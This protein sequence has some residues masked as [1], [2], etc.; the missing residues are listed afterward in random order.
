M[1]AQSNN[2][3]DETV[4]NAAG[5]YDAKGSLRD[6]NGS[7]Y[8]TEKSAAEYE[9]LIA[10][11]YKYL[12]NRR[13]RMDNLYWVVDETGKECI[14]KMRLAQKL[15]YLGLWHCSLVLK[16]RQHGI[17]TLICLMDF[18]TCF[19]NSN[20]AAV[21]VAHNKEDAEG[22]F[23]SKI[24][25]AYN[26]LP[27]F[28]KDANPASQS[29]ARKLTFRNG[30][31]IRVTTSGRSGT[32]QLAHISE[33]GKI[34]AKY[35]EKARE[36]VT[37]TLNTVHPG[38]L[39]TIESTAEGREGKFYDM[40]EVAQQFELAGTPLTQLDYK[41]F[42]FGWQDNPLNVLSLEDTASTV[43]LDYQ[44]E[45]FDEIENELRINLPANK[46][47][48]YV[49]KWNVQ[50]DD[51]KREHP[52]TAAEAFET[53]I[54]GSFYRVQFLKI[55]AEGRICTVPFDKRFLVDTWWDLG[56]D[57][58]TSIWF[59]QNVDRELH[60]IR[61]YENYDEEFKFYFD[62]LYKMK[63]EFG[64][65]YGKHTAPHDAGQ[66]D[67]FTKKSYAKSASDLGL[68]FQ[69]APKM[70]KHFG[71]ELVKQIL[72][73]T[74]F[75]EAGTTMPFGDNLVGVPS[76]EQYRREWNEKLGCYR[77]SPLHNWA[78]HGADAFRTLA[79]MHDWAGPLM[80]APSN[81]DKES[82]RSKAKASG[83]T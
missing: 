16:S 47:A 45:Y 43:L 67:K 80:Q 78:S 10:K 25:Y 72:N 46:K 52:S 12:A 30:S 34:C 58:S 29:S 69:V 24:K 3:F 6:A 9:Q 77:T 38:Q 4:Y 35:P 55:R 70:S 20:T 64:Y 31:S 26:H 65:D 60:V 82:A 74:W 14:F 71:I 61:Y 13:W 76:L 63:K 11:S 2:A 1:L 79:M 53:S 19:F 37:G 18:D 15:L 75:D 57:D 5:A 62:Y 48:W 49:K 44:A 51:M 21:I 73:M 36:I 17:T 59:T 7:L 39:V 8:D 81:A 28:L 54:K 42:F 22:F 32:Y 83:W 68:K 23:E 56:L 33:F 41:F 66:R 50:G 40:C 27:Q